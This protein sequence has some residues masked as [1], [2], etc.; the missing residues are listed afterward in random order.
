[1][2]SETSARAITRRSMLKRLGLATTTVYA[3]PSLLTLGGGARASSGGSGGGSGGSGGSGGGSG[4]GRSSSG[5]NQGGGNAGGRGS[6]GRS[7]GGGRN[8]GGGNRGGGGRPD[9]DSRPSRP[10]FLRRQQPQQTRQ[11]A[12][13][14]QTR[15]RTGPRTVQQQD[16]PP[17][18]PQPEFVVLLPPGTGTRSIEALGYGIL[19]RRSNGVMAGDI[20]RVR[21]P[22]GRTLAEARAEVAGALPVRRIDT[23]A[24]YRPN[25]MLCEDEGCAA[26]DIIGWRS[27][28]NGCSLRPRIGM[29]DTAVNPDQPALQGQRLTVLE[30]PRDDGRPVASALHGTAVAT[31]LIGRPDSRTPGLLPDAELLAVNAFFS[32][33]DAG[34]DAADVYAIA[35]AVDMLIAREVT[36]I[37]MSFS[38]PPNDLLEELVARAA[39]AG[40]ALVAAAGNG[41]PLAD[42]AYPAAYDDV[43]A[44]TA[45]D[46]R[47]NVYRQANRGSYIAFA[48][49]GVDLWTAASVSGG[50]LR[51]GTS[52]AAPFV[53]AALAVRR[54][55]APGEPLAESL[56]LLARNAR[57][58]GEAGPD[59][60]FGHGVIQAGFLCDL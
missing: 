18:R 23:N 51:S 5:G 8:A 6:G 28:R 46:R 7:S 20:L 45:I 53:T 39:A 57:D 16:P 14:Q 12:R 13:P 59:E 34:E 37:N 40:V 9:R 29:I 54:A 2:T 19:A 60:T 41:G 47:D 26:F 52:Y 38:G 58:L 32:E 15:R 42:P 31:L 3:A 27:S 35:E 30:V 24:L 50:R 17:A 43:I 25:A 44:V 49:P 1:M 55:E 33:G 10:R 11:Q 4:G 22:M 21:A 36:T 48:A 56:A